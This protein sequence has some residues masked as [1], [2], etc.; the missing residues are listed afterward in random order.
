MLPAGVYSVVT[1]GADVAPATLIVRE[2]QALTF[3][4]WAIPAS[5]S[6]FFFVANPFDPD[7][8][9]VTFDG[10]EV[11][12]RP[13]SGRPWI[14]LDAPPHAPGAVDVVVRRG[15]DAVAAKAG[16][17][18]YDPSDADPAVFEPVLYPVAY[19][20]PGSFGS[21]WTTDQFARVAGAKFRAT[22]GCEFCTSDL[23]PGVYALPKVSH[24]WGQLL[25]GVRGSLEASSFTSRIQ[26]TSRPGN[27]PVA[28]PVVRERDFRSGIL[29]F[30]RVIAD[31]H[32]RITLRVWTI[33]EPR[34]IYVPLV[35]DVPMQRIPRA[36]M[37]YGSLD[38]TG[39][40]SG[41]NYLSVGEAGAFASPPT[42][43]NPR[44]WAM[45]A[46]TRNDNQQVTIVGSY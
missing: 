27:M 35:G 16:V 29:L 32:T 15:S 24:P 6:R 7:P 42:A 19:E 45:L 17:I 38:V 22:P 30:Y 36:R 46:I 31:E 12:Q 37:W 20:G 33:D 5:G 8:V 40:V 34:E 4:T 25:Y 43:V 44:M 28:V 10:L 11:P 41:E 13:S 9:T 2:D 26:E 23:W 14:T 21:Q 18:Y 39:Q 1:E 3:A